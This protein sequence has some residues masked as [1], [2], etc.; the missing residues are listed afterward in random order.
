ME[1][2][3]SRQN[4]STNSGRPNFTDNQQEAMRLLHTTNSKRSCKNRTQV[5]TKEHINNGT[6]RG[7]GI[8]RKPR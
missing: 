7:T 4:S 3:K 8:V 1:R 6:H 5:F 2:D